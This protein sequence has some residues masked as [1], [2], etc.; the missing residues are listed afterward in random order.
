MTPLKH[1]ILDLSRQTL[2]GDLSP[3]F[4]LA[5]NH[6]IDQGAFLTP[7]TIASHLVPNLV[8]KLERYRLD[9]G[10]ETALLG[11]SGGVDSAL[12]AALFKR[13]GWRVVGHTLPIHQ[14]PEE[15]RRGVAAC[16]ALGIEHQSIDLTPQYD[17]M[18]GAMG[19][20][21]DALRTSIAEPVRVRLG[22][23]RARLRMMAL[24]D[25]A[26]R[27]GG[28]V[29]S[30]DNFSELTAGFWTLCGDVG[31][32]SPIQALIKSWE[33]PAAARAVGVPEDTWR[34]K[35][36]DGLG[37]SDGDEAQL[38]VS[39]LEWDL[40]VMAIRDAVRAR[41]CIVKSGLSLD[42]DPR[43]DMAFEAVSRRMSS[44]WFKRFGAIRLSH[45]TDDR[46]AAADAIDQRMFVP[47]AAKRA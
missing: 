22:N 11:M 29:A 6:R 9:T 33:V 18:V 37:I 42:G 25:Q 10:V 4:D 8:E 45:P 36:T 41:K 12:T 3:W 44:T 30:T 34:A 47:E 26:A 19:A 40:M 38:G 7:D 5:L 46:Y 27:Y 15:T 14:N 32:V 21:D 17:A 24:Y 2:Q 1:D 20:V 13:A 16:I 28:I 43:A 23:L 35:P 39:Y 31:D